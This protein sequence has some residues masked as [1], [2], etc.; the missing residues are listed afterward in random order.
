[1]ATILDTLPK[2]D[3]YCHLDGALPVE[4]LAHLAA[5]RGLPEGSDAE[6]L[7]NRIRCTDIAALE[8][9]RAW[10]RGLLTSAE[11]LTTA[12]LLMGRRLIDEA[13]LHAEIVV[14]PTAYGHTSLAAW[15]VLAAVSAG[16]MEATQ[17][18]EEAFLSW[19]LLVELRKDVDPEATAAMLRDVR[20][21]GVPGIAGVVLVGETGPIPTEAWDLAKEAGLGRVVVASGRAAVAEALQLGAQR[22]VGA[23]AAAQDPELVLPLRA[24]RLP[25]V[26]CPTAQVL[27]GAAK[28]LAT[29]PMRKMKDAGLFVVVA[30][31][32]PTLCDTSMPRELEALAKHQ[33]WRLDDA[34]N[35]TTRAIEAGFMDAKLRFHL[36]RTVEIWRHRPM[37]GPVGKGDNWSL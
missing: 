16:L 22:I 25:I 15:E 8:S 5:L 4:G 3:L 7:A 31:G 26:A 28:S 10:V 36:A 11:D 30:T 29:H 21:E 35:A 18:R 9:A 34:R 32:W 17:E 37:P 6:A 14:D 13:V 2:V 19:G 12:G 24:H 27:T 33:G 1:M 20:V 23:V